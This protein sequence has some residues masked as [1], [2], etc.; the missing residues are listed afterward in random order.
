M[1][2]QTNLETT[3][4]RPMLGIL[5]YQLLLLVALSLLIN[6]MNWSFVVLVKSFLV[7]CLL[8]AVSAVLLGW[9]LYIVAMYKSYLETAVARRSLG[10]HETKNLL[11][12]QLFFW[13]AGWF[14]LESITSLVQPSAIL[15]AIALPIIIV[16]G[17]GMVISGYFYK[18][19][20]ATL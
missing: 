17:V 5:G 20:L 1:A 6:V 9:L 4:P 3:Q 18:K 14:L 2:N 7:S 10:N 11:I 19:Y 16:T 13:L 12:Y 15:N 8:F